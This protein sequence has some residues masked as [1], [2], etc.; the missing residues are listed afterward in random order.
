MNI[1]NTTDFV[2]LRFLNKKRNEKKILDGT[3]ELPGCNINIHSDGSYYILVEKS[4]MYKKRLIDESLYNFIRNFC[5][6]KLAQTYN[7]D[8][9][10]CCV[11]EEELLDNTCFFNTYFDNFIGEFYDIEK[12]VHFILI[13]GDLASKG[14]IIPTDKSN[15]WGHQ[16]GFYN[17]LDPLMVN[18]FV[19]WIKLNIRP[20]VDTS[21]S[22]HK[23]YGT[24]IAKKP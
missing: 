15:K 22:F 18:L 19:E 20:S 4:S 14:Y 21:S 5:K 24:P 11:S 10:E 16:I 17:D 7:I 1:C 23:I 6:N 12:C 9:L 3:F 8:G 2:A 13:Y